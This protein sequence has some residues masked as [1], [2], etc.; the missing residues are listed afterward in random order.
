MYHLVKLRIAAPLPA[1]AE[2]NKGEEGS[3]APSITVLFVPSPAATDNFKLR[4]LVLRETPLRFA[5]G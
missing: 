1:Y 4:P 3:D 5:L 2:P